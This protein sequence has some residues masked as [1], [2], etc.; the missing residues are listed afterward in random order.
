ME[1]WADLKRREAAALEAR[2][3]LGA[4]LRSWRLGQG[5]TLA[6]VGARLGVSLSRVSKMEG[7]NLGGSAGRAYAE[8]ARLGHRWAACV[9][10]DARALNAAARRALVGAK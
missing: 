6:E 10:P 1:S 7:G 4:D 9:R 3:A 5:M 8:L 2:R